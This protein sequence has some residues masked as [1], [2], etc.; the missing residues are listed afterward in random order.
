MYRD[1]GYPRKNINGIKMNNTMFVISQYADDTLFLLDGTEKSLKHCMRMLKLYASASGL[2]INI[3]KKTQQQQRLYG[4][5][6]KRISIRVSVANVDYHGK[7]KI[8][9]FSV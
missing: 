8:L 4:L 2:Y 5:V 9:L 1:T 6:L 3:E 7:V